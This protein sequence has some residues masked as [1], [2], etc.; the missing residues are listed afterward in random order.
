MSKSEILTQRRFLFP[1]FLGISGGAVTIATLTW[2]E[3]RGFQGEAGAFRKAEEQVHAVHGGA[4]RTFEKVV[5]NRCYAQRGEARAVRCGI[6]DVQQAFV[7]VCHVGYSGHVG[8]EVGE[9]MIVVSVVIQSLQLAD[10]YPALGLDNR[11]QP[12]R[13]CSVAAQS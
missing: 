1:C 8:D 10:R 9:I 11:S 3:C 6:V 4:G 2:S 13:Q 7:G 12:A 5:D